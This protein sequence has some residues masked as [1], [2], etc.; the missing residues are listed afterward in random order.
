MRV[1]KNLFFKSLNERAYNHVFY[2]YLHIKKG[3]IPKILNLRNPTTFNEKIIWLKLNRR[4]L[5]AHILA[6]KVLVK[7]IVRDT[8]G[9]K[10]VIPTIAVFDDISQVDLN[11]LPSAFVLKANHGSTWNIIC[12]DKGKFDFEN[13]RN[14]LKSWLNTNYYDIGKEYQYGNIVPKVICE[15]YLENSKAKPLLDYKV[16]CFSGK[17]KFIQVDLDRFANHR[18]N[19]YDV[20][21]NLMPF[22]TL[23]PMGD[24]AL[25]KPECLD[26]ML[27]IAERLSS[28]I[29]FA[30]IDLYYYNG[31]IYFGEIT[32]HHGGGFEPFFP[33][34]Y[35]RILGEHIDLCGAL[36]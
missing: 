32:L 12:E 11:K 8:I 22:T 25:P 23:Y 31:S 16:F 7:D 5:N 10:Y 24:G 28:G 3:A 34:E 18:R 14:R 13:A 30:R 35:D 20:N 9:G 17:P 36:S 4:Y 15:I 33:R 29:T 19:F 27:F 2:Y 6:D 21:W 26:E 1:W